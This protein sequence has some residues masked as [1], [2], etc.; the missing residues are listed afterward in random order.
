MLRGD[1][2][3]PREIE[4]A[5]AQSIKH[6]TTQFSRDY[7]T[8]PNKA[9]TAVELIL[10]CCEA[11]AS[12]SLPAGASQHLVV[13]RR[14]AARFR[15]LL[16]D[17]GA[18]QHHVPMSLPWARP[19]LEERAEWEEMWPNS[20]NLLRTQV[21]LGA[22]GANCEEWF[23]GRLFV[24]DVGFAFDNATESS[25]TSPGGFSEHLHADFVSWTDVTKLEIGTRNEVLLVIKEGVS[26][27]THLRLQLGFALEK[28]RL[29][30]I[31]NLCK[32][33][34]KTADYPLY[35]FVAP[36][37]GLDQNMQD[38]MD[39]GKTDLGIPFEP[40]ESVLRIVSVLPS[41]QQMQRD[42]KLPTFEAH[43][44]DATM[45]SVQAAM[46]YV[47][48]DQWPMTRFQKTALKS[49]DIVATPWSDGIRMPAT[50]VRR[51]NFKL[52]VPADLPKS[53][54]RM[55]GIPPVIDGLMVA[56]IKCT[57]EEITYTMQS[58][59]LNVPYGDCHKME[60]VMHIRPH[61]DGGIALSRWSD[62]KFVK[63]MP[64]HLSAFKSFLE[65]KVRAEQVATW[66]L[67]ED[68]LRESFKPK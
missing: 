57:P 59:S 49:Y 30:E 26:S 12:V 64:W 17:M 9:Y 51:I 63:A 40:T 47:S 44:R 24:S 39:M 61:P 29:L 34:S 48:I 43:F 8:G 54:A 41:V 16:S 55:I 10:K 5:G 3:A 37:G 6:T 38:N 45:A 13:I 19:L 65:M 56:R 23:M 28:Q 60:D 67:F 2:D 22:E 33:G 31:W 21:C 15:G 58:C 7:L 50:L 52:P 4:L 66:P 42:Y 20:G 53:L 36:A 18:M 35:T 68:I 62:I 25:D 46:K 14:E 1:R 11:L 27:I 32:E